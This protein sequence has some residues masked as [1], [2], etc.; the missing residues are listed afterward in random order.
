MSVHVSLS[1]SA[2]YSTAAAMRQLMRRAGIMARDVATWCKCAFSSFPVG[3]AV[4]EGGVEVGERED[5][6]EG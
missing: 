4:S 6:G 3:E 2:G 1:L 5:E